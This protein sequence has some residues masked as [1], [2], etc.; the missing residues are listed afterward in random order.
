MLLASLLRLAARRGDGPREG[1]LA[2][3]RLQVSARG[4]SAAAE[5]VRVARA[6]DGSGRRDEATAAIAT[7]LEM[8]ASSVPA[9]AFALVVASR[10]A[11]AEFAR[12]LES[13]ASVFST[14]DAKARAFLLAGYVWAV[15]AR[16]ATPARRALEKAA[17][18]GEPKK[19]VAR[20]GRTLASLVEDGEW[21][22]AA[23]RD[24]LAE[25]VGTLEASTL[26]FE[27]L[28]SALVQKD[29]AASLRILES[30]ARAERGSH[31]ATLLTA[32][33]PASYLGLA[34]DATTGA[35]VQALDTLVAGVEDSKLGTSLGAL[36]ALRSLASGAIEDAASRA[37]KL[38]AA[39]PGHPFLSTLASEL[40]RRLG[41]VTESGAIAR[42]EAAATNDT[43]RAAAV[44]LEAGLTRFRAGERTAALQDF[45]AAV[46]DAEASVRP[47][48]TW[49]SRVPEGSDTASLEAAYE[50]TRSRTDELGVLAL[51]R[52]ARAIASGDDDVAREA[53]AD[54][55][56][57]AEGDVQ[58]AAALLRLAWPG[59][60]SYAEALDGALERIASRG[61]AAHELV[62][63][64]TLLA[65]RS[66]STDAATQAA[67]S[68]YAAG[69]GAVPALEWFGGTL[70][71]NDLESEVEARRALATSLDGV[72]REPLAAS[73]AQL[74]DVLDGGRG[75]APL[76]DGT[77][78]ASRLVNLDLA[79]PGSDP[80]RRG[81]ALDELD[82]VLGKDADVVAKSMAGWSFVVAGDFPS[83]AKA[84][85]FVVDRD[86]TDVTAWEGLRT[87]AL[88]TRDTT[89]RAEASEALGEQCRDDGRGA[90]FWEEAGNLWNELGDESRALE[91]YD[92]AFARD[93]SRKI[94]FD[95]IFRRAKDRKE[96]DRIL[97]LVKR[98]LDVTED[99]KE[100]ARLFWE[101]ARV[102]RERDDQDGA[103]RAL[104]NV[105]VLEP[106]HVGALALTGEIFIRRGMFAEAATQLSHLATIAEAPP[107][108]RVTAGVAAADL[109]ENKLDSHDKAVEVLKT[110]HD[111]GLSTMP[112]RERL[113]RA[114]ARAGAWETAAR[115]LLTLMNE[116]TEKSGRIDAAR[117]AMTVYRDR[118]DA[119]ASARPAIHKLLDESPA[120]GEA[121][122]LLLEV[123]TEKEPRSRYLQHARTTL[124]ELAAKG[125]VDE[126]LVER[127]V[128]VAKALQDTPLHTAALG[129][130]VALG[131]ATAD[132]ERAFEHALGQKP[133]VPQIRL[134]EAHLR[135]L[136][137]HGDEG[138]MA[139]LFAELGP[140]VAEAIGPSL[141]GMGV[142]KRD[143]VDARS[144]IALR[145]EIAAWCGALGVQ[146]FE[147]YVGGKDKDD[148]QGIPGETPA[149][150]VGAA[151][152]SPLPAE[153]RARVAREIWWMTRGASVVR[154]RDDTA[155]A[156]LVVA[157]CRVADVRVESPP[158]A[159]LAEFEKAI[160]KAISRKTKKALPPL[161]KAAV[162]S[163]VEP[164]AWAKRAMASGDRVAVVASGDPL[165][166]L[167]A[168][169]PE[170]GDRLPSIA[171]TDPRAQELLRF[172]LSPAYS[173][174]RRALGL[175]VAT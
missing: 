80:R 137:A 141:A 37:A 53:L 34:A 120:D 4:P 41:D 158:Y 25:D 18:L 156:A 1:E 84:F 169:F 175:E 133:R 74:R 26:R 71:A 22:D 60:T 67:R 72:V 136:G 148:V 61:P 44:L 168:A 29:G 55:D 92:A 46:G 135:A 32:L 132:E 126:Y 36:A 138:P 154:H 3:E 161:C 93:A 117:L 24:L 68:W 130:K 100:I 147:L 42:R 62:A 66:R 108:N 149:I 166:V 121:L 118:L 160:G 123:E 91:A 128:R 83:A 40:A 103:L 20:F 140:T 63:A 101:E 171:S 79:P 50:R 88:A 8:D 14:A 145:N 76:V 102:L 146:E 173:E 33:L 54:A 9:R 97:A 152:G 77:H 82:G 85:E 115:I 48:L 163:G 87:V 107:K 112:V 11:P 69:G 111:A 127:L 114:A 96:G 124:V 174:I 165:R 58:V 164:R 151:L 157:A 59:A 129:A 43:E 144:S 109:F 106:D 6:H 65:A 122:A 78:E 31:V 51:D 2:T 86:P 38:H 16:S 45:E 167:R 28:R 89:K 150:V 49:A 143:R 52:F 110:L 153:A 90:E 94:A 81:A 15:L 57:H 73:A 35:R 162:T 10:G 172:V 119:K 23:T 17:E 30:M 155:L 12:T 125:P 5:Y 139:T 21:Y 13:A 47:V 19:V 98:R 131:K 159:V 104:E 64:E 39:D 105:A 95:R 113:A 99:D 142:T 134:T 70:L 75:T 116:R 170:A 7:A 27:L 56:T